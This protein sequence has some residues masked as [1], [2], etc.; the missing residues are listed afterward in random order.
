MP[1]VP[2]SVVIPT[3]NEDDRING[4]ID[5]I[6]WA[7]EIIVA[8]AGSDDRTVRFAEARG[9]RVLTARDLTIGDQRN[10]AIESAKHAW[11]LALDADE[12]ADPNLKAVVTQVVNENPRAVFSIRR[13]NFFEGEEIRWGGWGNDW[14]VRLFPRTERFDTPRVHERLASSL[15]VQRLAAELRHFPYKSAD[16]FEE[17]MC[18]YSAWGAADLVE[19][20]RSFLALASWLRPPARVLRMLFLKLGILDGRRGLKLSLMAARSVRKKYCRAR[21]LARASRR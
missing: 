9:A 18:R 17:K 19:S 4:C 1:K 5:S 16:D 8:D 20:G 2:I 6:S 14:V 11:I 12:L 7:A 15:P 3:L 10:L 13:R 21:N